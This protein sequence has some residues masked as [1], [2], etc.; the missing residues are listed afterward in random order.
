M[1]YYFIINTEAFEVGTEDF[2]NQLLLSLYQKQRQRS[3]SKSY[4]KMILRS[5]SRRRI[6]R[7]PS[8]IFRAAPF[9]DEHVRS[10][11]HRTAMPKRI[12]NILYLYVIGRPCHQPFHFDL[13]KQLY[14]IWCIILFSEDF[15]YRNLSD[16]GWVCVS[17]PTW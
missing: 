7:S 1:K 17:S 14:F 16:Y 13:I 15:P 12:L 8:C 4:S 9:P 10:K 2:H 5:R 11:E 6:H 3:S